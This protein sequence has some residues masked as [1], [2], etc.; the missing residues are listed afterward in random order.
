[1]DKKLEKVLIDVV[2]NEG[3]G[4]D[5][6]EEDGYLLLPNSSPEGEDISIEVFF[7]N[8]FDIDCLFEEICS[9][10]TDFN[11]Q[12]H[13]A[14]WF[15]THG[16]NGAPTDLEV[17]IEDAKAIEGMYENLMTVIELIAKKEKGELELTEIKELINKYGYVYEEYGFEELTNDIMHALMYE[18]DLTENIAE[19][20]VYRVTN[21][22]DPNDKE[23]FIDECS[24]D[25]E[26]VKKCIEMYLE[27]K[28]G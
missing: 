2:E 7:E 23:I 20:I 25:G 18:Y 13:A 8:G 24:K 28:E 12:D 21:I 17:L 4:F 15:D 27:E 26:F 1:M 16:S 11:Y 6:N 19:E 10:Y 9:I 3:W 22:F 5:F 14:M